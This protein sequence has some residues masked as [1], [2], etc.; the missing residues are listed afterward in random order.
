M[1]IMLRIIAKPQHL[2]RTLFGALLAFEIL[3]A[4]RVFPIEPTFTLLGLILTLA[5]VWWI[6][7]YAERVLERSPLHT[8]FSYVMAVL[9][10]LTVYVDAFGDLFHWYATIPHYDAY[11]HF[12]NPAVA[13]VWAWHVVRALYPTLSARF[14][15]TV[16]LALTVAGG[17]LY[18]IE[19]YLEDVFTSSQRL[20][21]AWDTGNDLTMD[22]LG[23]LFAL[24]CLTLYY[25]WKKG[26]K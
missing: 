26:R 9:I 17:T 10:P 21:D 7:E 5:V 18:E 13:C 20:G 2:W 22:V 19:E 11:L 4:A 12:F 16:A 24:L 25:R 3:V 23:P 6:V 1:R 8:H 14:L 15:N